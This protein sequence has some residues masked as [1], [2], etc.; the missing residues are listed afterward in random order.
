MNEFTIRLLVLVALVALVAVAVWRQRRVAVTRPTPVARPDLGAGIH[1]FASSACRSCLDA[2]KV[3]TQ[4]YGDRFV[5]ISYEDDPTRFGRLG[6]SSVP[7]V[8]VLD[9]D[10]NGL[11]W[12]G[13]PRASDLPTQ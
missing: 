3:L 2:R 11:R 10:G 12:E 5:E 6:I 1:L 8:M 7:T 4:A 9:G 13:V